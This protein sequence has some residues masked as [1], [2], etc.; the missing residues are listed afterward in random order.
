MF[1]LQGNL[2]GKEARAFEETHVSHKNSAPRVLIEQR[3]VEIC[4]S[5]AGE[6]RR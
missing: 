3:L 5:G 4:A 2:S 6:G 1:I